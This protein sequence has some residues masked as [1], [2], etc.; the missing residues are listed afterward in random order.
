MS[1]SHWRG[2]CVCLCVRDEDREGRGR[3]EEAERCVFESLFPRC[4]DAHRR[5]RELKK[6]RAEENKEQVRNRFRTRI[7]ASADRNVYKSGMPMKHA[8][9]IRN[10]LKKDVQRFRHANYSMRK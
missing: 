1:A 3:E 10:H 8:Q 5:E 7:V 2:P 4:I 9:T 6:E